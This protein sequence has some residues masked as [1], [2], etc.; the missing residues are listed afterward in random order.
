M[1][2]Q[3]NLTERPPPPSVK[4]L[5]VKLPVSNQTKIPIG[6]SVSQ[7]AI[8]ETS[9][10][11]P[12]LLSNHPTKI[13]IGSSVSQIAIRETSRKQPPLLSDHPTKIPIAWFLRQSNYY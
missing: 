10:K 8:R 13:P 12:P 3:W 5:L 11:Q 6:S 9:R 7:I 1:V 2:L 4:L